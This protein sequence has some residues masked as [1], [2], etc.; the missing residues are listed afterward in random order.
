MATTKATHPSVAEITVV[1]PDRVGLIADVSETLAENGVNIDSISVETAGGDAI[2][3]VV[4]PSKT[5]SKAKQ[6]LEQGGFTPVESDALVVS[7]PDRPGE[8]ARLSR[9]FAENGI[10]I[11]NVYLLKK[12]GAKTLLA[13]KVSSPEKAKTL[14]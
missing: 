6:A 14:L 9:K 4:T 13:F 10:S 3:R 12:E 1:S 8:L 7:M 2:I 5:A 11:K